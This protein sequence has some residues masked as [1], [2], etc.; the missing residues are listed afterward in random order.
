MCLRVLACFFA[1]LR[2]PGTKG[3]GRAEWQHTMCIDDA[4]LPT[5]GLWGNPSGPRD[6]G[7]VILFKWEFGT[8]NIPL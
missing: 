3:G 1:S 6:W 8:R 7:G 4:T 2:L 5:G